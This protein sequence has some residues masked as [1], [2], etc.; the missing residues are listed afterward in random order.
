MLNMAKADEIRG[1]SQVNNATTLMD[2]QTKQ[3]DSITKR[4]QAMASAK[5]AEEGAQSPNKEKD[6][7]K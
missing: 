6:S 1:G 4:M 5:Q 3:Q 2:S 7:S